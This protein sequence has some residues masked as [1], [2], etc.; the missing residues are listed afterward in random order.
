MDRAWV[1]EAKEVQDTT[2]CRQGDGHS[3]FGRKMRYYVGHFTKEKYNNWTVLCK[4]A[5]PGEN[6]HP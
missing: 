5:G 6:R 4:L 2:I 3:M 1:L